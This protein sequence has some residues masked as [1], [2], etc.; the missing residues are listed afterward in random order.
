MLTNMSESGP[1][2]EPFN[3]SNLG[4]N[5][6]PT[7]TVT[8]LLADIEGSTRLWEAD[9]EAMT[10][11]VARLDRTIGELVM[12]HRGVRPV[13]QGEG[14]S[15]VVAFTRA[16]DA[17]AFALDLQRAPLE[18]VRLRV[19][20][21]TGEVQLRD[22]G[23]YVGPTIN[24]T[25]RLRDLAHGGQVV[26]SG[27]AQLLV[28]DLLPAD[29]WLTD[30][31]AHQLRDLP[32]PEHV[33]QLCHP[34]LRSDF[35]A[36]RTAKNAHPQRLPAQLTNFIGRQTEL[37]DLRKELEVN[38][39][40]TLTGAGGVG[41]TRLAIEVASQSADLFG[42]D[43]W[44]VGLAPISDPKLVAV[45]VARTLGLTD[46]PGLSTMDA[47]VKFIGGRRILLLVD[48]CEHLVGSVAELVVD[49]VSTCPRVV[50][51]ATSREPL[52]VA[53]EGTWRVPSLSLADEAIELFADRA[54]L[55]RSDFVLG[56]RH[57][58]I[59]EEICRRLDGMPLAIELAAA[60]VR[61]LSLADIVDGLHDRFRLLTGG[62]RNAVRRQQTLRASVEW[63]HALL[64]E[65]ERVLFRRLAVFI[66]GFTLDAAQSVCG[67]NDLEGFQ[68][69]D[70]IGLLVDKSLV[71]SENSPDRTRYRLLETVRQ[72]AQEKLSE[73]GEANQVRNR[74]HEHYARFAELIESRMQVGDEQT[75]QL[76]EAE[77][78]N[79][80]AAFAWCLEN[81]D[82]AGALRLASSLHPLW[83]PLG[84]MHEGLEWF[85]SAFSMEGAVPDGL[86]AAVRV[87]ALADRGV[88]EM[89]ALGA[90]RS[91][92]V[93]RAL[94]MARDID[95]PTLVMRALVAR[96][97]VAVGG[98]ESAD[99]YF[100]EALDLARASRDRGMLTLILGT[101]SNLAFLVGDPL[102]VLQSAEEG[103]DVAEAIG[104][105]VTSHQCR[106][107][108]GW[109]RMV[110]GDLVGAITMFREANARANAD[111]VWGVVSAHY[112]A[113]A[114][115]QQGEVASA[116]AI[117]E[118]ATPATAELGGLWSGNSFGQR[119]I[120][121]LA[122]GNAEKAD[123]ACRTA[124]E[125]LAGAPAHRQMYVYLA[126]EVALAADDLDTA[127]RS[128]DEAVAVAKGW[129]LVESLTTRARVAVR[130]S[131]WA[132][133]ER[134]AHDALTLAAD[135]GAHLRL[136]DILEC[137]AAAA[138][139]VDSLDEAARLLGAADAARRRIG[140]V[141]FVVHGMQF[142]LTVADLRAA[143]GDVE[144]ERLWDDGAQLS[145]DEAIA[146][147]RRGRGERKR[148]QT[149][150]AAL[151]PTERDVVRL[152][153]EGLGNKEI[154]ARLFVSH[155]TVE[156]HLTHVYT[157][158]ALKSRVQLVNEAARHD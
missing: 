107:W 135:L 54:R 113:Q 77:F 47:L 125:Q 155:R 45:T 79:V 101:Q 86:P 122:V 99:A 27:V 70:Q 157:K 12:A 148:P 7:G 34:E 74:H 59:V 152:V 111:Q 25:G 149:G 65:P 14:D 83:L 1:R 60:R 114:L 154:A 140:S 134:D 108:L 118:R 76:A 57:V 11:A 40:V 82:V 124:L 120:G 28:G 36:L 106:T 158:L 81:S 117:I 143:R 92:D 32:Q 110:T 17:V 72:H 136:P 3:W 21:H 50:V 19:G 78:G 37:I 146:F 64:T 87:R 38:R 22:E 104:D 89:N 91:D 52:G 80:R 10:A 130:S 128:A 126:A 90:G 137:L 132:K 29:A 71:V 63:S 145:N 151:T 23:N 156:T 4:M 88:L 112:E 102:A 96:G 2:I 51:L 15:F 141:R 41:K 105:R 138:A 69:F 103:R 30:L 147:A 58:A 109:T 66:G 42:G 127:N 98:G 20:I 97:F 116:D 46:R 61:A 67:G 84:R 121:A 48:N 55:A 53:G 6:L 33:L 129:F 35:P 93:E 9:S 153:S 95:D 73:S 75:L 94:A 49:L 31:G 44:Y 26:M 100:A 144:F 133:A 150:W 39:V 115:Y 13:E 68:V 119:T 16:S 18:P 56:D 8:L 85:D 62:A 123:G 43:V 5:E 139:G 131:D 142:D 24:R